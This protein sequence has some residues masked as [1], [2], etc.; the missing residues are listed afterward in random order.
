MN[1][2]AAELITTG[3]N[4]RQ[5]D[6]G[7]ARDM[8]GALAAGLFAGPGEMRE[9]FRTHPWEATPL[10]PL[11]GW[12]ASL[13]VIAQVVLAAPTPM[14]L[15]WGPELVQLYNDGY[16]TIMGA[17]HPGGLGQRN[18]QCWPEVW[19]FTAPVY[20]AVLQRG[21]ALAFTDQP[22]VLER[23]GEPDE[24]F[25]TLTYTPVPG[26][27]GS[28]GGILVTVHE[29]TAQVH[30]RKARDAERERLLAESEAA[31]ERYEMQMR[32]FEGVAS[33]T[34]DFVY[35]F[36][37]QGRFLY[38]NRR[39]LE[40]WGV[41]LDNA[42][43]KTCLELG[44][45]PWHHDM[46]MR[47]IAQV[48]ATR[49]AIKGEVP[50][51][52]PLTGIFGVYEYIFTPVLGADGE[53][54][55]IAGTTRDVTERKRA[56]EEREGLLRE[57]ELARAEA[58]RASRAKSEFLAVMSHELRTPL[59][60]IGGYA[61][62]MEMGIRGPVSD[63]QRNDLERIQQSQ[64]HLLGLINEVLNYARLESGAVPFQIED[65]P[66][67]PA[68][69]DALALVEPQAVARGLAISAAPVAA[70]LRVRTDADK[71]R[72]ILLNLLSN[73]VKFTEPGGR[74]DVECQ[75]EAGRVL[76]RVRD[77]GVGI[78]EEHLAQIFEPF[79]QVDQRLTRPHEGVGLGLA[80]SRDLA[81][82]TG[83]D[84]TAE[85]V[86]GQGSTFTLA[87]PRAS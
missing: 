21:E 33:T 32:L 3:G 83:G 58:E 28:P 2:G 8:A 55:I 64:R 75:D 24:G 86:P 37:R 54:E 84:L 18:Y 38:A 39:L 34:P 49:E 43:G 16:R 87:L 30:A 78:R 56:E 67:G 51:R 5:A 41:T 48:I 77:T 10:G 62:L 72:Q 61:E 60:A 73:A 44:Y 20:E 31:R 14:I 47:E 12:P 15:L 68:V 57:A 7:Q 23:G 25:F 79:V 82:A 9:R 63:A 1:R 11:E 4:T 69:A 42:V 70:A 59:N 53:V 81:R 45:E 36:D 52:A 17:K 6:P 26:D 74:V 27:D 65:V 13:R 40:V 19:R 85:S 76:L 80:I 46:H 66:L 35:L 29:T 22:L 50:F 71:L